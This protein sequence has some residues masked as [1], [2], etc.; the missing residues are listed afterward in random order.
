MG[1]A[2]L[3]QLLLTNVAEIKF[4]RRVVDEFKP[5]YRRML[6]T[7]S[8]DILKSINGRISLNYRDAKQSI[9]FD[10]VAENIVITWDIL[11]QDYRS[12]SMDDCQLVNKWAEKEFWQHFNETFYPMSPGDKLLFMNT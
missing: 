6:C 1:R 12:V 11:M 2:E 10:P 9:K 7:N 4:R 8:E 3:Q 5:P